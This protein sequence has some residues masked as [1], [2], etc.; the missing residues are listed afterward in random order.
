MQLKWFDIKNINIGGAYPGSIYARVSCFGGAYIRGTCAKNAYIRNAYIKST[1]T[2]SSDHKLCK[3]FIKSF[4]LLIELISKIWISSCLYLQVILNKVLYC[5]SIYSIYLIV[6][7]LS[8]LT[9][10]AFNIAVI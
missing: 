3:F 1:G 8:Q 9:S 6:Y 2:C 4:K 7:S 5:C 10:M